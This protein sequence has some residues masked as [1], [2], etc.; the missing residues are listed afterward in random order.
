MKT[1]LDV[2]VYKETDNPRSRL[3]LNTTSESNLETSDLD[4][5]DR[6]LGDFR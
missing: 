6:D 5:I 1:R 2:F 3:S 4:D